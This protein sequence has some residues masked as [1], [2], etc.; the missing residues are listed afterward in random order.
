MNDELKM[1]L[2]CKDTPAVWQ[3][4][5]SDRSKEMAV[6]EDGMTCQSR[7]QFWNGVRASKCVLGRGK[8]YYEATVSDEG[9]CRVG[10]STNQVLQNITNTNKY[11][12]QQI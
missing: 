3:L 7:N 8:Y 4:S 9:L 5:K 10:W 6:A 12:L 1:K 11:D 2:F